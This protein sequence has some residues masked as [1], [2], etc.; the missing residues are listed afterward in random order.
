VSALPS[1]SAP[2]TPGGAR[3]NLR[4]CAASPFLPPRRTEAHPLPAGDFGGFSAPSIGALS[5]LPDQPFL[6]TAHR[7]VAVRSLI[8]VGTQPLCTVRL[9]SPHVAL[10]VP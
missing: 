1:L 2:I 7:T 6:A 9:C 3:P 4:L 10:F 5:A 8:L